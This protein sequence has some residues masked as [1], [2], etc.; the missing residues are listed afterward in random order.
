MAM[1]IPGKT[2][3]PLCNEIIGVNDQITAFPAF[4][5][6]DHKFGRFSD[7]AFHESCLMKD[8]DHTGVEDMYGAYLMIWDSR[9][10]VLKTME[11]V[12]AWTKEA[13]SDWPPKNGVVIFMP[14]VLDDDNFQGF[15]MDAD[16]Y[17]DMCEAED[18]AEKELEERRAEADRIEKEKLH[19]IRD[20]DY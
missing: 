9:P 17:K 15:W 16:D 5:P 11:E 12:D 13:F 14:L 7:A 4:L 10:R 18:K 6:P 1:I 19:F 3:C 8:P 20:D 2:V